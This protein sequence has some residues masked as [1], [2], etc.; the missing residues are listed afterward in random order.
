MPLNPKYFAKFVPGEYYHVFN[1]TNG[2]HKL[3]RDDENYKF[4]LNKYEEYLSDFVDTYCFCLLPSHFH[5]LVKVK[6]EIG[7]N[8]PIYDSI[9]GQEL[10]TID[11]S[12]QIDKLVVKRFKNFF[13][14][15]TMSFNKYHKRQGS[16]FNHRF[17]RILIQSD[18]HLRQAVFYIH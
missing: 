5:L 1:R 8:M 16:L 17:K 11:I 10:T 6:E 15:Y 3:F 18:Q 12:A 9:A 14:S 2:S 7:G 4:F 13:I